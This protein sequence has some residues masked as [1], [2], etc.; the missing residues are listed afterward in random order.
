MIE[1]KI[2]IAIRKDGTFLDGLLGAHRQ[3]GKEKE[4][5]RTWKTKDEEKKQKDERA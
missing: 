5:N 3:G 4:Q 2:A 1:I